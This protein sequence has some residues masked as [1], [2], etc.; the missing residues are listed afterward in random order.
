MAQPRNSPPWQTVSGPRRGH[1]LHVRPISARRF[2]AFIRFAIALA[3]PT[4]ATRPCTTGGIPG[5]TPNLTRAV[6]SVAGL[7]QEQRPPQSM[8]HTWYVTFEVQKRGTLPKARHPR[9]TKAFETETEAKIFAREKFNQGLV[10]T[11]GTLNPHSPKQIIPSSAISIWL[12]SE[13]GQSAEGP[14]DFKSAGPPPHP[15]DSS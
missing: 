11:A 10:V 5:S 2:L 15:K 12:G 1:G 8:R 14:D 3:R 7:P 4:R 6:L 9:L 13:Q